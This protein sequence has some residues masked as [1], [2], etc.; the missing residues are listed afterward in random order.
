MSLSFT[1][2]SI[3]TLYS[4]TS[5]KDL[6]MEKYHNH[7]GKNIQRSSTTLIKTY[8][9]QIS[10]IPTLLDTSIQNH[11]YF[12]GIIH[13]TKMTQ[14]KIQISSSLTEFISN[15]IQHSAYLTIH[16]EN[17]LY[18]THEYCATSGSIYSFKKKKKYN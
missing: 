16:K 13:H 18:T 10:I 8:N 1:V 17:T 3:L 6:G 15:I 2:T 14:R 5:F 9:Y 4:S 11:H 12:L 7:T